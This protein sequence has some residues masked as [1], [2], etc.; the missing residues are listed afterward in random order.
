VAWIGSE[1]YGI[2]GLFIGIAAGNIAGG[3][4][5][6]LYALW[7]R[8]THCVEASPSENSAS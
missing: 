1:I 2:E 7:L 8:K 4:L 6:Y 3:L 5:G